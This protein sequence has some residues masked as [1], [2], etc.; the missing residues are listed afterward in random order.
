MKIQKLNIFFLLFLTY[1]SFIVFA[2]EKNYLEEAL[3]Y[4]GDNRIELEKV[5]NHYKSNSLKKKAA[6]FLIEN[7]PGHYSYEDTSYSNKYYNEI[8]RVAEIYQNKSE[9]IKDSL[10]R[11]VTNQYTKYPR[12]VEDIKCIISSFLIDN[13]DSSFEVWQHGEW[14]THLNFDEFCEYLLPYKVCEIQDLDHWKE[15]FKDFCNGSIQQLHY[16]HL[17]ENAAYYACETV[18][19]ALRDKVSPR[20]INEDQLPVRR[21]ST[22]SKI[23]FGIC[24]DYTILALAVMRAKGIPTV[25]DFTPQWPYRSQGHSWNVLLET[26]G[27]K[28]VFKGAGDGPAHPHKEEHRMAKA[29][30]STY[31]INREIRNIQLTERYLPATFTPFMKDVTVEYQATTT[32]NVPIQSSTNHKYA[33]LAVFDNANWVPIYWGKIEEGKVLFK[34]MGRRVFY[35]PAYYEAGSIKPFADP[36][37]LK[38]NGEIQQLKPDKT[39]KQTLVLLRKYPPMQSV[40]EIA[41]RVIGGRIQVAE[42]SL[43]THSITLHTITEF[44]I[45]AKDINLKSSKQKFRYWRYYPPDNAYC[46]IAELFFYKQNSQQPL[47]GKTIG[48]N[49]SVWGGRTDL[50]V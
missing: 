24:D 21:M 46:N 48:T 26:S 42:D 29:F 22:L 14:A 44:G 45:T 8:D 3:K 13:I 23:P 36:V 25:M 4:A 33:Y 1:N 17:F 10:Y 5:I 28:V 49:G 27:K 50:Y 39:F 30:R 37:L 12:V 19:R 15:Y 34:E 32:I 11:S 40:Y 6:V 16:C 47:M 35:L 18:N 43:F 31:A 2:Q 9:R 41:R 7:M 38:A 20:L